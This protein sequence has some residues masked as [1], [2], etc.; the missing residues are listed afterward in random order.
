MHQPHGFVAELVC[1][2]YGN[3][4]C[5]GRIE[6][7][8][9]TRGVHCHMLADPRGLL[10]RSAKLGFRVL[11]RRGKFAVTK[12]I[13]SSFVDLDKIGALLEL[14]ADYGNQ[15]SGVVG[16][17]GIREEVLLRVVVVCILVSAKD[18]HC[19]AADPQARSGNETLVNGIT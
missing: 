11:I 2:I 1:M 5:T 4:S 15:F 18:V 7:T 14:L 19:I 8:G 3:D 10:N 6:R 13:A 9:F 12:R 16:P 17:G